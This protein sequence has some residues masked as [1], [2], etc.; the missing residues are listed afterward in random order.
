MKNLT[1]RDKNLE[2]L[3]STNSNCI[4]LLITLIWKFFI[5]NFPGFQC[6]TIL[7]CLSWFWFLKKP[8]LAPASLAPAVNIAISAFHCDSNTECFKKDAEDFLAIDLFCFVV[9]SFFRKDYLTKNFLFFS[10]NLTCHK[11]P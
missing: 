11:K 10:L 8:L 5:K 9:F 6:F 1:D 3:K 7:E 4:G 2:V